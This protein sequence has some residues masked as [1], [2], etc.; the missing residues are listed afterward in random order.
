MLSNS[1]RFCLA[2]ST[3]IVSLFRG[4]IRHT[5]ISRDDSSYHTEAS[6]TC[7]EVSG[8]RGVGESLRSLLEPE[9][10]DVG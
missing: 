7:L 6:E 9:H 8:F 5:A 2:A 4:E 3:D 1:L 10:C